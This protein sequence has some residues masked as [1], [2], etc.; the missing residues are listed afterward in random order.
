MKRILTAS[1][2]TAFLTIPTYA[3]NTLVI[4]TD[5]GRNEIFELTEGMKVSEDELL[6]DY[7]NRTNLVPS[8]ST[9][10]DVSYNDHVIADRLSRIPTM[11]DLPLNEFTRKYIDTYSTRMKRSVS[12]MLGASNFYN[13]IFEEAL[14]RYNLPLELKFLPVIESGLR[15]SATSGAGAAGLWQLIMSTG[16]RYG[17]EINTLV[18]ERRDPIRSSEAAAHFL[19]DL[20]RSFGDWSLAIAAYNCGPGNVQKAL[21]RAGGEKGQHDFW[22]IYQYLPAET[23]GYVPAFVAATYIMNYYCEHGITP[24]S[25][26]L[27]EESDTIVV[28]H[29][30]RM[31]AISSVCGVSIDELRALNPQYRRDIVPRSYA[32]RLPAHAIEAFITQENKI[33]DR[34]QPEFV[35]SVE[36]GDAVVEQSAEL[37]DNASAAVEVTPLEVTE[38]VEP[39]AAP[40][41]TPNRNT[42]TRDTAAKNNKNN[43]ASSSQK[44]SRQKQQR[45]TPKR[46][47]VKS[48]DSL[49][50][51][52]RKNGTTVENLRRLNGLKGTTIQPGQKL[53]VK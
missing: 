48:G 22:S 40:V 33:Y 39:I 41:T 38:P 20:Y 50:K 8:A 36:D 2:L 44:N 13:P 16:K 46:V 25:A 47:E 14:E 34:V 23:R 7:N 18:D 3:Q 43:K 53:R 19:S 10:R 24:M 1:L 31:A 35:P 42:Y 17:L 4:E 26:T 27:P 49:S 11:I 15:P 28:A 32:V 6:R 12:V 29:D 30:A 9:A 21:A 37:A 45:N 51:I 52:A 5:S